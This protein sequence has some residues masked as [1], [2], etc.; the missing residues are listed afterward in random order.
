MKAFIPVLIVTVGVGGFIVLTTMAPKP[1]IIEFQPQTPP[2][3]VTTADE[4]TVTIPVYSRGIVSPGTEVQMATEVAGQVIKISPNFANGGFFDKGELLLEVDAT[5]Y[6]LESRKATARL[7]SVQKAYNRLIAN[8]GLDDD[9]VNGIYRDTSFKT[10]QRREAKANLS[11][12][13]ADVRIAQNQIE[14]AKMY[15]P[16]DGRVREAFIGKGQY[17]TPGMQIARVYS[18]NNAEVRLPLSDHQ[19]SLVKVPVRYQGEAAAN[20]GPPVTLQL[21]FAGNNFFWSGKVLRTEGGID[22]RNRLMYVVAQVEGPYD[23]DPDQPERPPLAAGQFIEAQIQGKTHS[24]IVVLPRKVLRNGDKVWVVD[25]EERLKRKDVDILHKGRDLVYIRGGLQKGDQVVLSPLDIAIDGMKVRSTHEDDLDIIDSGSNVV[26]SSNQFDSSREDDSKNNAEIDD[27]WEVKKEIVKV[28]TPNLKNVD[29]KKAE[30]E[31]AKVLEN[32]ISQIVEANPIKAK[33]LESKI[34]EA[35][36]KTIEMLA[37]K[38][39]AAVIPKPE[40]KLVSENKTE[41]NSKAEP[42]IVAKPEVKAAPKIE[43]KPEMA[44]P[45]PVQQVASVKPNEAK[46][47][48]PAMMQESAE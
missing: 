13:E 40:T 43:T 38:K 33:I 4:Q 7:I 44:E 45:T 36:V 35:K 24:G 17:V 18:V 6:K 34:L 25:Q 3:T 16:F 29:L 20:E 42:E 2:V 39:A 47:V 8:Q 22:I 23:R 28:E 15:A 48:S 19:M 46:A 30:A 10:L 12:A 5:R 26:S 32:K 27:E 21:E 11:A 41:L 1:T 14:K 31:I 9:E 37:K